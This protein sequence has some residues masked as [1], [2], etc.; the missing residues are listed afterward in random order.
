LGL[1]PVQLIEIKRRKLILEA[2]DLVEG[3]PVFDIKPYIPTY[4]AFPDAKAGWID[5]VDVA[6]E[7]PAEYQV[8]F[9]TLAETQAGWLQKEWQIDFRP[10]LVELLA[11]DP[12]PHRTRRITSRRGTGLFVIGC[13]AWRA[14][15]A[16][17]ERTVTVQWLEPGYPSR[18]LNDPARAAG[19][20]DREAQLAFL[21]RWPEMP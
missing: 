6:M 7:V 19:L 17:K 20:P 1:T 3:T 8:T 12:A 4:D 5:E 9:S 21:Q 14:V 11:R 15:F 2:C 18:F 10:R 13:G 16:L